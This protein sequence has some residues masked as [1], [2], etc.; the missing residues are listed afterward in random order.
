MPPRRSVPTKGPP[1]QLYPWPALEELTQR[2]PFVDKGRLVVIRRKL[3]SN[4]VTIDWGKAFLLFFKRRKYNP[5]TLFVFGV[6]QGEEKGRHD[7]EGDEVDQDGFP[8]ALRALGEGQVDG[9]LLLVIVIVAAAAGNALP[10]ARRRRG[11]GRVTA[12]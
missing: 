2:R 7:G 8:V 3:P 12:F 10:L 5:L 9:L 11:L 4:R 6:G 1:H